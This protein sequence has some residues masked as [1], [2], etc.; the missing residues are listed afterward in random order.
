[1]RAN[2]TLKKETADKLREVRDMN[3]FKSLDEL[4]NALLGF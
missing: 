2:I 3:K 1:M 4:V